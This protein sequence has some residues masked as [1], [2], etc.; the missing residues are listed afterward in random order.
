MKRPAYPRRPTPA[1]GRRR[2]LSSLTL[3]TA[4][5]LAIGAGASAEPAPGGVR[6]EIEISVVPQPN[7]APS[8]SVP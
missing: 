4:A 5:V 2:V 7:G 6:A 3:L 8:F 1:S